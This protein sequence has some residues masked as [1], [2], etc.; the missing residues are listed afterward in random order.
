MSKWTAR[1]DARDIRG[2]A[3]EYLVAYALQVA[4]FRVFRN[5]TSGSDLL[6]KIGSRFLP[7]EVKS[8]GDPL[9]EETGYKAK[10]AQ[11]REGQGKAMAAVWILPSPEGHYTVE[12]V[13][14][15]SQK[16]KRSER[17]SNF[18]NERV[19]LNDKQ[20]IRKAVRSLLPRH[21]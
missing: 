10:H 20:A 6:V 12:I 13:L 17:N 5:E 4:N 16:V 19:R 11:R 7:L 8:K 2:K 21:P 15:R 14:T 18:K 3:A 9:Y 1:D